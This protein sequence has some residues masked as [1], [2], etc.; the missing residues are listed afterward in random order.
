MQVCGGGR[1]AGRPPDVQGP[2]LPRPA[3]PGRAGHRPPGHLQPAPAG[4]ALP[5]TATTAPWWGPSL[6]VGPQLGGSRQRSQA[7][8]RRWYKQ[9]RLYRPPDAR[10]P[11]A[12]GAQPR[13]RAVAGALQALRRAQPGRMAGQPAG[14]SCTPASCTATA[15]CQVGRACLP[16]AGL[17]SMPAL[18]WAPACARVSMRRSC[19]ACALGRMREVAAVSWLLLLRTCLSGP[20]GP[21]HAVNMPAQGGRCEQ[22]CGLATCPPSA[23][24]SWWRSRRPASTV[25]RSYRSA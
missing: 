12:G 24:A 23:P 15:T 2:G 17:P 8:D 6:P 1:P 13:Q 14:A 9:L 25:A 11:T 19:A 10:V 5:D 16:A 21:A 22:A 18:G 7:A 3:P 4:G 20:P